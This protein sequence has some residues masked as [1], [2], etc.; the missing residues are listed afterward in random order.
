MKCFYCEKEIAPDEKLYYV[1]LDRPYV[2]LPFHRDTCLR[3]VESIEIEEYLRLNQER[4][5]Q[6]A[7]LSLNKKDSA[8]K[9]KQE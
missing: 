2:M 6:Y 7:S 9:R 4:V 8:I 1:A 3:E 5:F